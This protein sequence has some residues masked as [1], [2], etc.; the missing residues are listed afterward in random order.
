[1]HSITLVCTFVTYFIEICLALFWFVLAFSG[2]L[3]GYIKSAQNRLTFLV[4]T[5]LSRKVIFQNISNACRIFHF[6]PDRLHLS[7]V[8]SFFGI[9]HGS[10]S[11]SSCN[12]KTFRFCC[13]FL[14]CLPF[15]WC[16]FFYNNFDFYP[17]ETFFISISS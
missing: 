7:T 6:L 8:P 3:C 4:P 11:T 17:N 15:L 13:H 16:H 14:Q 1:M 9:G 10:I 5:T 12:C 2:G